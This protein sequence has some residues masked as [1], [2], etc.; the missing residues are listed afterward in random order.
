MEMIIAK[1]SKWIPVSDSLPEPGANVL[2]CLIDH[3]R[4]NVSQHNNEYK[5]SIRIDRLIDYGEYGK[6]PLWSKW[7]SMSVVAW[8]PIPEPPKIVKSN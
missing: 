7:N 2:V 4:K 3:R 8:M 5:T 1:D 6:R